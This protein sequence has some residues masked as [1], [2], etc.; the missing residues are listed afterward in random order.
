[1]LIVSIVVGRADSRSLAVEV[2]PDL[3]REAVRALTHRL[4]D[5]LA[6]GSYAE[7][8]VD[9]SSV[10]SPTAAHIEALARLQLAA[11]RY[12]ARVKLVEPCP[13]LIDLLEFVG[14]TDVIVEN[15][16]DNTSFG[17]ESH[18]QAEHGE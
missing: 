9:V 6:A 13:G 14:L 10:Q 2:Y 7:V 16:P 18:G 12:R 17:I 4:V 11:Q 15:R 3:D 1:M 8:S 5:A